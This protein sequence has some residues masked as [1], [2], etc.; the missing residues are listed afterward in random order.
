MKHKIFS[1]LLGIVFLVACAEEVVKK[2]DKL[3]S[4]KQM[5][6]IIFDMAVLNATRNVTPKALEEQHI[7]PDKFIF[8][9]YNIDSV[10]FAQSSAYYTAKTSDFIE[11][12][13][14]VHKRL[15]KLKDSIDD[16]VKAEAQSRKERAAKQ[17]DSLSKLKEPKPLKNIT[18]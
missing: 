3:I 11:I 2:P 15:E 17:K 10:Q 8:K 12:Y 18:N 16:V 6:N 5:E 9:K 7:I 4:K 1:F 13:S 14:N